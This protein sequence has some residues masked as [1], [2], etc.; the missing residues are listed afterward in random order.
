MPAESGAIIPIMLCAS[1]RCG[2]LR[3]SHRPGRNCLETI[4][5]PAILLLDEATAAL[6]TKSEAVVQE[7]LDRIIE[8]GRR[9]KPGETSK[10]TRTTVCIA[11]RLSTLKSAD[12]IVVLEKGILAEDGTHD[13]LMS[14]PTGKY[15]ALAM[16][17]GAA[18][19]ASA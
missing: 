19:S 13:Q 12:R 4:R 11:H 5:A 17:Q 10:P 9:A 8:E 3:E 7:A 6:D 2:P 1:P 15:R 18:M 14:I 16:A